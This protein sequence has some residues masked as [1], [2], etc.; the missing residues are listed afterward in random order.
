MNHIYTLISQNLKH[1]ELWA[2]I[3]IVFAHTY[4]S[5]CTFINTILWT[6]CRHILLDSFTHIPVIYTTRKCMYYGIS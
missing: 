2:I 4:T 5:I 6:L 3:L 1:K